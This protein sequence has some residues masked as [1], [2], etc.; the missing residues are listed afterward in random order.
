MQNADWAERFLLHKFNINSRDDLVGTDFGKFVK[1]LRSE[2]RVGKPLLEGKTWDTSH[3][4]WRKISRTSFGIDY[5]KHYQCRK[6]AP[7]TNTGS[8]GK[9][10]ELN[11]YD[12]E[13]NPTYG[14]DVYVQRFVNKPCARM[15]LTLCTD[16]N[17]QSCYIQHR[18]NSMEAPSSSSVE[19]PYREGNNRYPRLQDLDNGNAII[20]FE[21]SNSC[22]IEDTLI[23]A[24]QKWEVSCCP[25]IVI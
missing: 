16:K 3:D 10:M 1:N 19:S 22:S 18:E 25:S 5:L 2:R 15:N 11:C 14:W 23:I 17:S 21:N 6:N 13:D 20:I 9:M 7:Q 12:E 8:N 24:R 4:P